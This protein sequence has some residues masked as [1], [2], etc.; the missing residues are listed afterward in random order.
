[1]GASKERKHRHIF[2]YVLFITLIAIIQI[3]F[4][5]RVSS[6]YYGDNI[7]NNESQLIRFDK[8]V[9]ANVTRQRG[10]RRIPSDIRSDDGLR[11]PERHHVR[12]EPDRRRGRPGKRSRRDY[13]APAPDESTEKRFVKEMT[14]GQKPI[15]FV[16]FHKAGGTSVCA[17]MSNLTDFHITDANGFEL[18]PRHRNCNTEMSGPLNDAKKY[19]G[20][21]TCAHL[22]PYT[23]GEDGTPFR[24][25]NFIAIEV[26]FLEKMPCAGFRSFAT[27]RDPVMRVLSHL[28]F[29]RVDRDEFMKLLEGKRVSSSKVHYGYPTINS[30][31]IRLLLG[32]NRYLDPTPINDKDLERAKA[33]VDQFDAFIPLEFLSSP[34]SISV[35]N[36][37][38]PEYI[39]AATL[40][41][42]DKYLTAK[43][44]QDFHGDQIRLIE[45]ENKHDI[46]L[47]KY[48]AEKLGITINSAKHDHR[49]DIRKRIKITAAV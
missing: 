39:R 44:Y 20:L 16:H 30:M 37:T 15:L 12:R 28:N 21:Q 34:E 2:K 46:L 17:K 13:S 49:E 9:D 29:E 27:I 40:N 25:N 35:L 47:Y 10:P 22:V 18:P 14:N 8:N 1:M 4:L 36:R 3:W 38:V 6:R 24:R 43:A 48:A 19:A 7:E 11:G 33:I 41:E 45:K 32:R 23:L 5:K 26:P 31:Q 42:Q